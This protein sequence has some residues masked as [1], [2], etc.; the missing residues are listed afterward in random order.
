MSFAKDLLD[1]LDSRGFGQIETV[2]CHACV[3]DYAIKNYIKHHGE[4]QKCDYCKKVRISYSLENVIGLI[5]ESAKKEYQ[6]AIDVMGYCSK[7]GGFM[8][9]NTYD[10]WEF[11]HD[12]LNVEMEIE[13]ASLLEDIS[14][15]M[16]FESWCEF[17]PYAMRLHEKDFSEWE[18]FSKDVKIKK[19][20]DLKNYPILTNVSSYLEQLGVITYSQKK[21]GFYRTLGHIKN[22]TLS[23]SK[24]LG[25][26]PMEFSSTNRFSMNGQSMF[27][28]AED[29]DTTLKEIYSDEYEAVTSAK[30]YPTKK[31]LL[32]DLTKI[33]EIG[34]ISMFDEDLCE[35]RSPFIFLRNFQ[36]TVSKPIN[37]RK[38]EYLPTQLF[39]TYLKTIFETESGE[40][41][42]GILYE[43]SKKPN[44]T[45][46]ALFFENDEMTDH[47]YTKDK[48]LYMDQNTVITTLR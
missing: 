4:R 38:N 35:L 14:N 30:F 31:L 28:G 18:K 21:V 43:S 9:A 40:Q 12:I 23:T 39:S 2:V 1:T 19:T 41:L 7:E 24:D 11:V 3:G 17:N 16:Y 13:D 26:P 33:K 20:D 34:W 5:V 46:C 36:K 6:Y 22:K 27:Y 42:D 15:T 48:K 29:I 45:C 47:K 25:S 44:S 8:G 32:L 37:G 10:T